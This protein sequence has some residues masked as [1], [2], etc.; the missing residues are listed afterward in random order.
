MLSF[1]SQMSLVKG[2][3]S[4]NSLLVRIRRA[5]LIRKLQQ[6]VML[7][8]VNS[9][10][11]SS[12]TTLIR[13]RNAQMREITVVNPKERNTFHSVACFFFTSLLALFTSSLAL[14]TALFALFAMS[15]TFHISFAFSDSFSF[16]LQAVVATENSRGCRSPL[17]KI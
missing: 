2:I 10:P 4:H 8:Q 3:N 12:R 11:R 5:T 6:R 15:F 7:I 17:K 9:F 1:L 13:M 16:S 14:F